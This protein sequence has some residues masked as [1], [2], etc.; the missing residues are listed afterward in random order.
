MSERTLEEQIALDENASM[1]NDMQGLPQETGPQLIA[2]IYTE[3]PA[4]IPEKIKKKYWASSDKSMAL[5]RLDKND[6]KRVGRLMETQRLRDRI[7]MD[8]YDYDGD[9]SFHV[10]QLTWWVK[11]IQLT[12]SIDGFERIQQNTLHRDVQV[13]TPQTRKPGLLGRFGR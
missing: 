10:N 6:A 13:R 3:L 11:A 9:Y 2:E 7:N 5:T 12:K 1:P 4:D 8:D